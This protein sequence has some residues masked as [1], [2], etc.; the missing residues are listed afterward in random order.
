[1]K[2]QGEDMFEER[3]SNPGHF[4]RFVSVRSAQVCPTLSCAIP[5][6]HFPCQRGGFRYVSIVRYA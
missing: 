3:G 5:S 1:M 4:R 2:T 6:R